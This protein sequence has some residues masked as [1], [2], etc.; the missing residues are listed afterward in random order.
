M[1]RVTSDDIVNTYCTG[2]LL[3]RPLPL[4]FHLKTAALVGGGDPLV[5]GP[6]LQQQSP[7]LSTYLRL[8]EILILDWVSLCYFLFQEVEAELARRQQAQASLGPSDLDSLVTRGQESVTSRRRPQS[9]VSRG[10]PQSPSFSRGG[11]QSPSFSRGGPQSPVDTSPQIS[12]SGSP[13]RGRLQVTY[14]TQ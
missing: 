9:S 6:G 13:G 1:S 12:A 11:P 10:G 14:A 8:G 3:T 2:A 4:T 5:Q 7:A